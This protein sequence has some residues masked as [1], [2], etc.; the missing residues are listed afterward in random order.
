MSAPKSLTTIVSAD[1][2]VI[3]PETVRT[4][5]EWKAGTRLVVENT[6][7]GVLLKPEPVFAET[8]PEQVF[9]SLGRRGAPKLMEDMD[10]S[11]LAEAKRRHVGD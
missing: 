2:Q 5:L 11:I 10:A 9:G 3:I 7:D 8:S 4:L 1:G 6:S